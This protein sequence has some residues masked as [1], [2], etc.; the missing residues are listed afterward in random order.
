MQHFDASC[1]NMDNP[2]CYSD[3]LMITTVVWGDCVAPFAGD[4]DGGPQ[5]DFRDIAGVVAKFVG[6]DDPPRVA[7]ELEPNIIDLSLDLDFKDI[8]SCVASFMNQ[9]YPLAGPTACP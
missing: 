3:S 4:P 7:A 6:R 9:A 1:G 5:P 2:S 8:S